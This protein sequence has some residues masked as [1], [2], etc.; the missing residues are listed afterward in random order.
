[1]LERVHGVVLVL[2][3]AIALGGAAS[4]QAQTQDPSPQER[5]ASAGNSPVPPDAPTTNPSAF[6]GIRLPLSH[7]PE[8]SGTAEVGKRFG[9]TSTDFGTPGFSGLFS[10]KT[11]FGTVNPNAPWKVG[12]GFT[13]SADNGTIARIGV[14]G[15]RNYRTPLFMNQTIG[16]GQDLT[17]PLVSF[18]DLSQRSV[19]WELVAGVE[20][21]LIRTAGGATIGVVADVFVPLNNVSPFQLGAPE[22]QVPPSM[23]IR[24]GVKLGF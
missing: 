8:T 15:H 19:Q 24:G 4:A 9:L 5:P 3:A 21:T 11:G 6:G 1:M 20:K 23:T 22:T 16:G 2:A 12:G 18:T 14:T 13:Y 7:V 17:L 10:G